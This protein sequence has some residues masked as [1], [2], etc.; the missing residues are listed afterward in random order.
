MPFM[1]SSDVAIETGYHERPN[2]FG[3]H[4]HVCRSVWFDNKQPEKGF[5]LGGLVAHLAIPEGWAF[6][7]LID[8]LFMYVQLWGDDAEYQFRI[9]LVRIESTE[10][11]EREVDLGPNG[12]V[13]EFMIPSKRL[14]DVSTLIFV[15]EVAFPIRNVY[16]PISGL[17]EFQ[18]WAEGFETP[19]VSERINV[20]E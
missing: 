18:L 15:Q 9:R 2:L 4:L 19:V 12:E 6:P 11:E 13:R 20:S 8:K 3:R 14:V 5:S 17:Y 7:L 16:F 10:D 1:G